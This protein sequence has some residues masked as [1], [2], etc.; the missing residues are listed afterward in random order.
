MSVLDWWRRL[1]GGVGVFGW[2]G[3]RWAEEPGAIGLGGGPD[4]LGSAILPLKRVVLFTAGVGFF[5][6]RGELVDEAQVE[7]RFRTE[8]INDLLKTMVVVDE[9]G[10]GCEVSYAAKAPLSRTLKSFAVD[11]TSNPTMGQLLNQLRGEKVR[12]EAPTEIV[13]VILGV[14]TR[15]RKVAEKQVQ[16]VEFLNLVTDGGLRSVELDQIRLIQ[17]LNKEICKELS[18]ALA[19]LASSRD[20][21]KRTIILRFPGRGRRQARIGYLLETPVWKTSYRLV[22]EEGKPAW[23]QGWAIVENTTDQDWNQVDLTLVSGRPVSFQMELYEPVYLPRPWEQI[24]LHRS[25][26]PRVHEQDLLHPEKIAEQ[27][28]GIRAERASLASLPLSKEGPSYAD[29]SASIASAVQ[30]IKEQKAAGV[31]GFRRDA[32]SA[33]ESA[34]VGEAFQYQIIRPVSLSRQ[35]SAMLPILMAEIPAEKLCVYNRLAH[36]KHPLLGVRITNT[37][38]LYLMQGPMTVFDEGV[39]AGETK[40]QDIPPGSQ[41]LLSYALDLCVE[42]ATQELEEPIETVR[43]HVNQGLA[44]ITQRFTRRH[45]YTVKNSADKVRNVLIEHPYD[46]QWTLVNPKEPVEKT[47]DLYRFLLVAKPGESASLAVEEQWETVNV[48]GIAHMND[49]M[50]AMIM[51]SKHISDKI[52][53]VLREVGA[54]KNQM[55]RLELDRLDLEHQIEEI[56]RDQARIR[57]NLPQLDK[58]SDLYQRYVQKLSQQE[59]QIDHLQA[60]IAALTEQIQ[61]AKKNL[62]EYIGTLEIP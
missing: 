6:H 19:V 40:I 42:V 1:V 32:P 60:Q 16:N 28:E 13:G 31:F 30:E 36:P 27:P 11:L 43:V 25:L 26:R 59:D 47:R 15:K 46:G 3:C 34:E 50:L 61:A 57:K 52:K 51:D 58:T 8:Q 44:H 29:T 18:H 4:N 45:L 12:L 55:S 49:T 39:Y 2:P 7:L 5:E 23:L 48:V 24:D 20:V 9:G 21:N 33:A 35:Q 38:P 56:H 53:Q 22:L 14:E 17:P 37:S 62:E 54:M 10:S 41:R